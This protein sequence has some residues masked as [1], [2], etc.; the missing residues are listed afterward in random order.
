M[1][2][3]DQPRTGPPSDL[4]KL[5]LGALGV[6]YGDIGTSP[7]YAMRECFASPHGTAITEHNILGILSLFFWSLTLVIVV[8]YLTFVMRA[9]NGG[10]GGTFALIALL[11]PKR[12]E[13]T[14]VGVLLILLGLFGV[15]LLSGEGI[16]TPAV[17][18]LSAVEGLKETTDAFEPFIVPISVGIILGVFAIQRRGTGGVGAVF[19]P[20]M[21]LWFATISVIGFR[22]ILKRPDVLHA[23]NPAYAVEFMQ[24][25]GGHGFLVLGAVVLCFTGGEALY[26]DMGH[27]GK[28]PIR[29]AWY[30][31]V[32]P[33][34]L[35][36]YF[37]QGALLLQ[38]GA[39][40]NSF[41]GL[42]DGWLRLPLSIIATIAAVIA[43]QALISG[44]FSLARAAVQLGFFPRVKIVHTSGMSEG[45]IYVP[46]VNWGLAVACI[47]LVL[48]FG[49][50]SK[51]A[52]AYGI[53]VTGTMSITSILFFAVARGRWKWSL[54]TAG[55]LVALFLALD[56]SFF[57]ANLVK[58]THGGWVPLAIGAVIFTVM[59]TW[60]RGRVLLGQAFL[61]QTLPLET[62][63]A[64]I[65]L[66]KPPRVQGTAVIMTSNPKGAPPVLLHHFK[67]N[68]MLHEQVVLLSIGTQHVPEVPRS[69]RIRELVNLGHGM[70]QVT[71]SYGFMQTPNVLEV[72][73]QCADRG[74]ITNKA[75]TS[76][77]L[78]RETLIISNRRGLSRWRKMLFAFMSRN[79]RP[80]NAFFQ[81]PPNRVIE[82]GTQI[83]L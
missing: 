14:R 39:V 3:A 20:V 15:S 22:W 23:V 71:A 68:K 50:S 1:G 30:A 66:M 79:A 34:L 57:S 77:F 52:A 72:L 33:A 56:L 12:A 81:I 28:G 51:L 41:F 55:P 37:G 69:Q 9:D 38:R 53:A 42:V 10:E 62:F 31:V 46:E 6:V 29:L 60:R 26:A 74:L 58:I 64:D 76:F 61:E 45:Q 13:R 25:H 36:N 2:P 32:F 67:H 40:P 47:A 7:L 78:G 27:F 59:T 73:E 18:V 75:D 19:G 48:G 54:L 8:K 24:H 80:A 82:L 21:L 43:S 11:D 17:S 4:A 16:I 63:M 44:S 35:L 49:S 5:S 70:W 65:E 83:E